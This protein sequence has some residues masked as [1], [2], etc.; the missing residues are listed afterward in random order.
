MVLAY[1]CRA[2]GFVLHCHARIPQIKSAILERTCV[3]N[4]PALETFTTNLCDRM[5]GAMAWLPP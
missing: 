2:T 4:F 5:L 1:W 3:S